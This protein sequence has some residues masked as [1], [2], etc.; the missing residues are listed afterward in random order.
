MAPHASTET[1][2]IHGF[3]HTNDDDEVECRCYFGYTGKGCHQQRSVSFSST[4][5]AYIALEHWDASEYGNLTLS[6][7][8]TDNVGVI[9]YYG[10]L[11]RFVSAELFDGRIKV[12]FLLNAPQSM[13]FSYAKVNDGR[14]HIVEMII[15]GN[16]ISLTVD[17]GAAQSVLNFGKESAFELA[18]KQNLLI[19]GM[20]KNVAAAAIEKFHVKDPKTFQGCVSD[21]YVNGKFVDVNEEPV[22]KQGTKTG[23]LDVINPCAT[24][25][26]HN[27][28]TCE[29]NPRSEEGFSCKCTDG[30]SGLHCERREVRCVK[31]KYRRYVVEGECRS[32]DEIKSAECR[33]WCGDDKSSTEIDGV[34]GGCCAAVRSKRRRVKMHCKD[35][36]TRAKVVEIIRKCECTDQCPQRRIG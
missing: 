12:A 8:T 19:G 35:G 31:E 20:P 2:P 13:I 15:K 22:A 26:C 27:H 21:I 18:T 34:A 23:C 17:N 14:T 30:Y 33:G 10:D 25:V 11:E 29:P 1:I 5:D 4:S 16:R 24:A 9:A 36:S 28:G 32:A 3:C 7:T 6:I